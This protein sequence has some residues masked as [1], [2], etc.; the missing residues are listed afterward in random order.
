MMF[1][2]KFL[3]NMKKREINRSWTKFKGKGLQCLDYD[4]FIVIK[5]SKKK[6]LNKDIDV[7]V[8]ILLFMFLKIIIYTKVAF[9]ITNEFY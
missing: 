7:K 2:L 9:L 8:V 5:N 3:E 6:I 1:L 4:S